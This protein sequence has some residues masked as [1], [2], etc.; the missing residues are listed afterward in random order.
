[1][2]QPKGWMQIDKLYHA[3]EYAVLGF[4]IARAFVGTLPHIS[5]S[6]LWFVTLF[7]VSLFG[8]SDEWHQTFV[9]NRI[10]SIS[11]WVADSIGGAIGAF[12]L[13][14]WYRARFKPSKLKKE[15]Q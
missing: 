7:A 9:Q 12:A 10:G 4:L 5:L 15:L 14:V 13:Y 2:F 6:L 3:V 1:M 8:A 11:D